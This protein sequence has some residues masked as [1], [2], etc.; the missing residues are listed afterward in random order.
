MRLCLAGL[1][2]LAGARA[3]GALGKDDSQR[4]FFDNLKRLCGQ[5]FEGE[6]VF[7]LDDPDHP[8]AGKRLVMHVETCREGEL[9]I[10]FHVGEDRSR[11]WV[12]TKTA[13]GLVF[14]HDH[15]HAD[16]TPDPL[17]DYGGSARPGGTP[18]EQ[19]FPADEQTRK[20]IPEAATNVW[21]LRL[22]T[23]KRQ[24]VYYLERHGKPR[25]RAVFDLARPL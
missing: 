16:G 8:L 21:I 22:D 15:R 20:L 4:A 6:T 19:H 9:R 17:T 10:P 5:K 14:K 3:G 7:P 1:L 18:T 25:Y 23:G 11:T 24:F 2:L 12:L 13:A